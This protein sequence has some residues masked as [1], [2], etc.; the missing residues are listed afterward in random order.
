MK[1]IHDDEIYGNLI[2]GYHSFFDSSR[3]KHILSHDA[4][5]Y[6]IPVHSF[7][8]QCQLIK[9]LYH[10]R[11]LI[12]IDDGYSTDCDVV[13]ILNHFTLP[14]ISFVNPSNVNIK[15]FLTQTELLELSKRITI[16]SHGLSHIPLPNVPIKKA[17][18]SIS[19]SKD[20]IE[21]IVGYGIVDFAFPYGLFTDS[22]I[23][24]VLE[25]GFRRIYGTDIF[26]IDLNNN[27]SHLNRILIKGTYSDKEF[28]EVI[29]SKGMSLKIRRSIR[30]L[31]KLSFQEHFVEDDITTESLGGYF[32]IDH[33]ARSSLYDLLGEEPGD[34][35]IADILYS[36][37]L[38]RDEN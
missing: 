29:I 38:V 22:L 36:C 9:N 3:A 37:P 13:D 31:K 5:P 14:A 12:T 33:I 4:I 20:M 10:G 1:I 32:V 11:I 21:D 2:L 23:E 35:F 27:L 7:K 16:G 8:R 24:M 30:N 15:G 6:N 17:K 19:R 28:S 26:N 18:D 34:S 25:C